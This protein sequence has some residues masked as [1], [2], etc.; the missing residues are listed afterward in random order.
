MTARQRIDYCHVNDAVTDTRLVT[1]A[2]SSHNAMWRREYGSQEPVEL[3]MRSLEADERQ[4]TP[5]IQDYLTVAAA[6]IFKW[7]IAGCHEHFSCDNL[8]IP[9]D[10]W[11]AHSLI[12][13]PIIYA[14]ETDPWPVVQWGGEHGVIRCRAYPVA[15]EASIEEGENNYR[16]LEQDDVRKAFDAAFAGLENWLRMGAGCCERLRPL[17]MGGMANST[18]PI[19]ATTNSPWEAHYDRQCRYPRPTYVCPQE[20]RSLMPASR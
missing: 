5:T 15:W 1:T 7:V 13:S 20:S 10:G 16:F 17:P 19:R 4:R 3:H 12:E 14:S 18:P 9:G 2:P 11:N 8:Y 6:A